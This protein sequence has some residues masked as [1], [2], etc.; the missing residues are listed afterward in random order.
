MA[1]PEYRRLTRARSRVSDMAFTS[2]SSLWLGPDHLLAIDTTGYTETYK[3]FHFRDIQAIV[4]RRSKRRMWQNIV[5]GSLAGLF[6]F[7]TLVVWFS[8]S[9]EAAVAIV[10]GVLCLFCV[11][12]VAI[13]TLKGPGCVCYLRTAVQTEE[14]PS[15]T[16]IGRLNR[17][18]EQIRPLI[19]QAQGQLDPA[20][21][22]A[23]M[24]QLAERPAQNYV[25]D[26]PN[27]PPRI[28]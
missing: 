28:L 16:R 9:P 25:V 17:V 21:I 3:R 7:M 22:P 5:F 19:A 6:A 4:A 14:L 23:R 10:F 2:N 26:D 15:L 27:L 24:R 11:V 8:P 13:N 20:E 12:V 1:E 18:L